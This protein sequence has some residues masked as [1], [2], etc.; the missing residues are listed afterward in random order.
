MSQLQSA[1]CP[2]LQLRGLSMAF[3]TTPLFQGLD[4]DLKGGQFV[5]LIGPNGAGKTTLLKLVMGLLRP[6]AGQI[7]LDGRA[8]TDW[9][10][11]ALSRQI[12]LVPQETQLGFDFSVEEVVAMGRN[13]YLGRFQTPGPRDLKLIEAAMVHTGVQPFAERPLN[14]LS[15]GERQRVIIARAIAQ[16]TPI[17]LLDEVTANLDLSHQLEILEL[18]RELARQGR[19]VLAAMHDLS[20]AS[21]FCDR[22]LLL[23]EGGIRADGIPERVLTPDNLRD[24]FGIE[25]EVQPATG[26]QGLSVLALGSTRSCASASQPASG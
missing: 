17:L 12:T 21:R 26:G 9:T 25:A 13:P 10:R 24:Y 6:S 22:L 18:A 16:E 11:R 7:L 19:L 1:D 20:M 8:L 23:S 14:T 5:G 15:G 4:L 3:S 2:A